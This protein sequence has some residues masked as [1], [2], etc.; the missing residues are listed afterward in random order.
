M[1]VTSSNKTTTMIGGVVEG[2][3]HEVV[4]GAMDLEEAEI[5][6]IS[7]SHHQVH[8]ICAYRTVQNVCGIF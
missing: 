7:K 2:V 6:K 3:A 1:V 4:G 5:M 8:V